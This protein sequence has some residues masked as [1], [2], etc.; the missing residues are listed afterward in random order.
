MFSLRAFHYPQPSAGGVSTSHEAGSTQNL[1]TCGRERELPL[2]FIP[3]VLPV[4]RKGKRTK[5]ENI[6]GEASLCFLLPTKCAAGTSLLPQ[7]GASCSHARHTSHHLSPT[8][9]QVGLP[10]QS[11]SLLSL[12]GAPSLFWI[13][14]G[15]LSGAALLKSAA[16]SGVEQSLRPL[17]AFGEVGCPCHF[18]S[19]LDSG[20]QLNLSLKSLA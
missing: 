5:A 3:W 17:A 18:A 9:F 1:I 14:T 13:S 4:C 12:A 20:S 16:T 2:P 6:N 11:L 10:L 7:L 15:T 19:C 8:I